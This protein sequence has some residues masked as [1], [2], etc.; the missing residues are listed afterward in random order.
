MFLEMTLLIICASVCPVMA[1]S[2]I[3]PAHFSF[4]R[5][6]S[7]GDFAIAANSAISVDLRVANY[8]CKQ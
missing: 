2:L 1:I 3:Y 6:P 4:T 8:S 5:T 7:I